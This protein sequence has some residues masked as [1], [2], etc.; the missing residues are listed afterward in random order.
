ME[1]PGAKDNKSDKERI[2]GRGRGQ[3][4]LI[5]INTEE[6]SKNREGSERSEE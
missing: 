5:R 3:R 1:V 6:G 2:R 4:V